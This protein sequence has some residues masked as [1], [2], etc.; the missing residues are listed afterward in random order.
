MLDLKPDKGCAI[1]LRRDDL[2]VDVLMDQ[3]MQGKS[4][5]GMGVLL[6]PTTAR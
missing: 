5:I 1:K 3:A 4:R 6:K 2:R